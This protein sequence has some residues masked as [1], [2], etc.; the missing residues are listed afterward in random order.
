MT[1]IVYLITPLCFLM[2]HNRDT[3]ALVTS[4]KGYNMWHETNLDKRF[5][6]GGLRLRPHVHAEMKENAARNMPKQQV[7]IYS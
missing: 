7:V 1:Q 3:H 5:L 2:S 4:G 6:F